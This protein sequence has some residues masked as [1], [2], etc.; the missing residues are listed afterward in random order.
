MAGG[1]SKRTKRRRHE[2]AAFWLLRHRQGELPAEEA[3]AFREW[4]DR[5]PA[6]RRAY[7]TAEQL[8]GDARSAILSDPA[9][10]DFPDRPPRGQGKLLG[11]AVLALGLSGAAF[12][13][14]DGPMRLQADAMSGTGDMPTVTL[15]D[16]SIVQLNA[17]SAVAFD[18]TQGRR[19]VRLL[20]GQAFFQVAPDAAR[21]FSVEAANGTVTALGT[22]FDIRLGEERTDVTVT[23]HVVEIA[24]APSQPVRLSEGERAHYDGNGVVS[25]IAPVDVSQA[26][27]WRRGQ[28]VVEGASLSEVV[29]EMN[30][31]F[32]GRIVV[33]GR[34]LAGRRISGTL[35]ITDTDA[36]L[37]FIAQV[38]G[39]RVT[40]VGPLVLLSG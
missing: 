27:A 5:D 20:R 12:V 35:A 25:G 16:G 11:I 15:T 34:A 39:I 8:M 29:T 4:L 23:E 33:A 22:A 38:L 40:R 9:L 2:E 30:R 3:H 14:M 28:L 36:T 31:H 10:R 18:Y 17:S 13:L 21:P 32:S 1:N 7:E 26:L 6:N 37:S 19:R 24:S